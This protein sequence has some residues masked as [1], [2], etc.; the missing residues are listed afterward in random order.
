[1]GINDAKPVPQ[2]QVSHQ[3]RIQR[4]GTILGT[5][6]RR[7]EGRTGARERRRD[8]RERDGGCGTEEET[9]EDERGRAVEFRGVFCLDEGVRLERGELDGFPQ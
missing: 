2:P 3:T 8:I 4:L 5:R 6:R 1:M 7:M 9:S